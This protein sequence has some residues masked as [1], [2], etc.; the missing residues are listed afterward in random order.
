MSGRRVV[1]IMLAVLVPL[2]ACIVVAITGGWPKITSE[3]QFLTVMYIAALPM[4]LGVGYVVMAMLRRRIGYA[5]LS[6]PRCGYALSELCPP[7]ET[8][9]IA[10]Q[11]EPLT[12]PECGLQTTPHGVRQYWLIHRQKW[13]G[14]A[15]R[16]LPNADHA[17][18]A[19]RNQKQAPMLSQ[20]NPS[21][22]P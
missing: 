21:D 22:E 15:Y 5:A 1:V 10:R 7:I 4:A 3:W 14:R 17:Q 12:C 16:P 19:E 20:R 6:C 8:E 11:M 2:V 13:T 18:Q 9:T